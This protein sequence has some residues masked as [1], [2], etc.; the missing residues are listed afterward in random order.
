MS[1]SLENESAANDGS[2]KVNTNDN[3]VAEKFFCSENGCNQVLK[4]CM[5]NV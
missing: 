5:L 3:D 2:N 1:S 4:S